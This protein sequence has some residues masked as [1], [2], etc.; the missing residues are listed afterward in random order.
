MPSSTDPHDPHGA[1]HG[2]THHTHRDSASTPSL[3]Q[4][5][6]AEFHARAV[7]LRSLERE[8]EL[9]KLEFDRLRMDLAD[10]LERLDERKQK[11]ALIDHELSE[12]TTK[13]G[14]L[15]TQIRELK[16]TKS[17]KIE[18]KFIKEK[19]LLDLRS[20]KKVEEKKARELGQDVMAAHTRVDSM[21]ANLL[22]EM[23]PAKARV[24]AII[25]RLTRSHPYKPEPDHAATHQQEY[26]LQNKQVADLLATYRQILHPT[27]WPTGAS[28]QITLVAPSTDPTR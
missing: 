23:T 6:L 18:Q 2:P 8:S 10:R 14:R 19:R 7:E 20:A 4:A 21:R 28:S 22:E 26:Q 9:T 27:E 3:Q 12:V 5:S 25:R 17:T 11:L 1:H 24:K 16:D 13:V 15:E